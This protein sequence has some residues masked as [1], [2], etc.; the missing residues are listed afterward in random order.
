MTTYLKYRPAWMQ[1]LV[2]GSFAICFFVVA[3]FVS[4]LTIPKMYGISRISFSDP[5]FSNP[6]VIAAFKVLQ[7]ITTIS[8]FMIPSLAFAYMSDH[9]PLKYAGFKKAVPASFYIVAVIIIL[10]SLPMVS[11][12]ND[13]NQHLHFPKSMQSV[14]KLM[15]ESE[16][17]NDDLL[18]NFLSMKSL[19]DLVMTLF[20][21]A[22]L[23]AIAEELFFRGVLQRLFI[24]IFKRPWTGIIVTAVIF[25]AAHGQ[26]LGFFP[27]VMLG[28]VLGALYWYSGSLWPGIVAHFI[29]NGLQ[30]VLIYSNP[31]IIDKDPDFSAQLIAAS[32]IAVIALLWWMSRISH[33]RYAEVYDTDDFH[34]GPRDQYTV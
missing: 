14:E 21:L 26:F 12:I 22:L 10:A 15:R 29:H 28:I 32:T 5:D 16:K 4:I 20:M 31:Q 13:L 6:A 1:L 33:T 18:K 24:Q 27:R 25:S 9:H 34:I 30:V 7:V 3:S 19:K 2:F 17:Q 8:L 23:P 11:W